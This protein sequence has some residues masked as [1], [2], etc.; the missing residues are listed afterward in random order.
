MVMGKEEEVCKKL[1]FLKRGFLN[2]RE[3]KLSPF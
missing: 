1:G 3:L 2:K